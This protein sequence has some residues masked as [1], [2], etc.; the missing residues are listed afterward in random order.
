M[1]EDVSTMSAI[2]DMEHA[3]VNLVSCLQML[4]AEFTVT[5]DT[6]AGFVHVSVRHGQYEASNTH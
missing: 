6:V 5:V 4:N 3:A 2:K 1:G